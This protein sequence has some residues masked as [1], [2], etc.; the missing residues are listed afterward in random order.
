MS[1]SVAGSILEV[2]QGR[3]G[4]VAA[5][6]GEGAFNP[7]EWELD[8]QT[9]LEKHLNGDRCLGFYLLRD[10]DTVFVS[11]L[12]VDNHNGEN[13]NAAV[14]AHAICVALD[15]LGLSY[16]VERSQSGSGWHIWLRFAEPIQASLARKLWETVYRQA[17]ATFRF[18]VYPRQDSLAEK[19]LGNLIRYPLWG[20]SRFQNMPLDS[21]GIDPEE[22]CA[23]LLQ[24][25]STL[26]E[27]RNVIGWDDCE[28]TV[29]GI[30]V[31]DEISVRV[32]DI[33]NRNPG[34]LLAKRW[35]SQTH[36]M[37][38]KSRSAIAQAI[39][40]ELVRNYVPTAEIEQ[41]LKYWCQQNAY[42]KGDRD[43]WVR[44][45]VDRSYDMAVGRQEK[46]SLIGNTFAG[47]A[48]QY[49]DDVAANAEVIIP[50]GIVGLDASIEGIGLGELGIISAAPGHGKTAV[51][52]QWADAAALA[53]FPVL[54]ISLEM[55]GRE[56]SRRVLLRVSGMSSDDWRSEGANE[57]IH[58]RINSYFK[59]RAPMYFVEGAESI[60][61]IEDV[62]E[63][64]VTDYGVKLVCLDYQGLAVTDDYNASEYQ[65]QTTITKSL[66]KAARRHDIAILSLVQ[67]NRGLGDDELPSMR[68]LKG[69][70]EIE[71]SSDLIVFGRWLFKIDPQANHRNAYLVKVDKCR[72]RK[73]INP[74]IPVSF[75]DDSQTFGVW[76]A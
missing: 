3:A 58:N 43:L 35:M 47:L 75:D 20:Q 16:V 46:Q 27:V 55:S 70:G 63:Q 5:D 39:C 14:D 13:P 8:A 42:E 72:N 65:A 66:K 49:A 25:A 2:F 19:K 28:Q 10:D 37:G 23:R 12:D 1:L 30:W 56:S 9:F 52:M 11:A 64:Y 71:A 36:G 48:H 41:A 38:D 17:N 18:E 69:S 6:M 33:I 24:G 32:A 7:F 22:A 67:L 53:G 59:Q 31:G 60:K 74:M 61:R 50:S 29:E 73:V 76:V 51:A 15:E 57:L 68:H 26:N 44:A 34:S 21:E 62:I 45:T 40:V 4:W 54:L